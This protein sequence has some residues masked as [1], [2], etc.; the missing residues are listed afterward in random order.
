MERGPNSPTALDL[1]VAPGDILFTFGSSTLANLVGHVL[2]VTEE[3]R[4]VTKH[5]FDPLGIVKVPDALQTNPWWAIRTLESTRQ[6]RGGYLDVV[7]YFY[8]DPVSHGILCCGERAQPAEAGVGDLVEIEECRV[9]VLQHPHPL[10]GHLHAGAWQEAVKAAFIQSK[11]WSWATGANAVRAGLG[12]G[13][14][15]L[16]FP[17]L[18]MPIHWDRRKVTKL[19]RRWESDPICT[20]CVIATWQRY[21]FN[22]ARP[23]PVEQALALV[24][25]YMPLKADETMPQS[26]LAEL[27][28]CRWV[29]L[30]KV[31]E[32]FRPTPIVVPVAPIPMPAAS[33]E[34]AVSSDCSTTTGGSSPECPESAE[35]ARPERLRRVHDP[36][37]PSG[38]G[39]AQLQERRWSLHIPPMQ[40][41]A[42]W[43]GPP[44]PPAMVSDGSGPAAPTGPAMPRDPPMCVIPVI[45]T[46]PIIGLHLQH[47]ETVQFKNPRAE[48]AVDLHRLRELVWHQR[49]V[50]QEHEARVAS[51]RQA[52]LDA[53]IEGARLQEELSRRQVQHL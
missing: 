13:E 26:M 43:S 11:D 24:R 41:L 21:F 38:S 15:R 12:L 19:K 48:L 53:E 52:L 35:G 45:P 5:Q 51:L 9:E 25:L 30:A 46:P 33:C 6:H 42:P 14:C 8:V 40:P 17:E 20:T 7:S 36:N 32:V 16:E 28:R 27:Q 39:V 10:R 23:L 18:G 4:R 29:R 44:P 2:L 49:S 47:G 31:P 3:P 22:V 34:A 50:E 37:S 1:L